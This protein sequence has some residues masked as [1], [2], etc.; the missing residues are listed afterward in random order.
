M[1]APGCSGLFRLMCMLLLRTL[2][3]MV[4]ICLDDQDLFY[5]D[6]AQISEFR[7]TSVEL[8]GSSTV[9]LHLEISSNEWTAKVS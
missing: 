2:D 7:L 6:A 3:T 9:L 1:I 4:T 5:H 8:E